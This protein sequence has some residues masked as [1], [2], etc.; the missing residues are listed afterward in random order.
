MEKT[1][2]LSYVVSP[3]DFI[4][5]GTVSEDLRT[6][7]EKM[8]VDPEIIRKATLAVYESEL[9]MI[10][11]ANGG[12]IDVE[13]SPD[14]IYVEAADNGPGI[15]DIDLA[16]QNGYTTIAQDDQRR[17]KGVGNGT[18]FSNIR[19]C[20]DSFQIETELGQGT[21]LKFAVNIK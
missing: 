21:T 5:A 18:G 12:L 19:K 20:T 16:M 9:N 3:N 17:E 13:I 7:L 1:T 14:R 11:H 2:T 15:E 6:N 8:D 10:I 4:N